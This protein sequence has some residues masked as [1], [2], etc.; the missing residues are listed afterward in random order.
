MN[1]PLTAALV[2]PLLLAGCTSSPQFHV[3]G[4]IDGA[5]GS[6]LY[7]E[8]NT[9]EG[10]QLLDSTRLDAQGC[11]SFTA[12]AP[13][14]CPEFYALRIGP[15]RIHFSI[16]ST[17]TL[18]FAAHYPT[19]TTQY[20]VEGSDNA[21]RIRAIAIAQQRLQQQIQTIEADASLLPGDA[22]DSIDALIRAYKEQ[23]KRTYIYQAPESAAAYYAVCQSAY[24]RYGARQLFNPLYDRADVKCYATVATAWDGRWPD[25]PRTV[26]LCN[27]ASQGMANTAPVRQREL[28]V[29]ASKVH[30]SGLIDI[31]LPDIENH[32]HRLSDLKG[33]VVL[34]D[35]T[36]YGAPQSARRTRELRSLYDHY[37]GQGLQIYQ[38]SLDDDIHF[39]KYSCEKLPWICVHETDG[40]STNLYA[41]SSLPT[42][43]L[44]NRSN[45]VVKRSTDV[46]NLEEEIKQ[47]L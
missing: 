45:E 30:E 9:L 23:M 33:S 32:L 7:L 1:R 34:L 25:A 10:V 46:R 4:T 13:P 18:H 31:Q 20:T 42:F 41:V 14:D 12:P 24:D 6:M 28:T 43:F 19:M 47:L 2:L 40:T 37:H 11:F 36:L 17:E 29:D 44:I 38:I 39:W 16:D 15:S 27:M 35:F 3:Q 26:Q 8:A 22:T 21:V 5:S